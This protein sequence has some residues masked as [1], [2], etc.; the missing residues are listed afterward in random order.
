MQPLRSG[1]MLHEKLAHS[2]L[3]KVDYAE[4]VDPETLTTLEES[5]LPAKT[6]VAVAAWV[7]TTRLIDNCTLQI[8][9]ANA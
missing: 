9:K 4:L 5:E 7:G 8:D 1:V 6:L 3:L 2:D